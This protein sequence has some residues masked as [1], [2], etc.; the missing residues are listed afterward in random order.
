MSAQ[1]T[2]N[3]QSTTI[4]KQ[5]HD[6]LP[7]VRRNFIYM[8]I[9]GAMIVVGFLLMLGG[10]SQTGSG[11]FNPEIFSTRRIVIGPALAF[12]GFL[13]MAIAIIVRPEAMKKNDK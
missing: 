8:A 11:D 12:L 10:G 2:S 4:K 3:K 9:A 13:G 1:N 6:T 5:S 7:L